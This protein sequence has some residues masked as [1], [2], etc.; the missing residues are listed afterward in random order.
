[1][2]YND[3]SGNLGEKPRGITRICSA[4]LLNKG[5]LA[6]WNCRCSN[7]A[8]CGG[9]TL[10]SVRVKWREKELWKDAPVQRCPREHLA[11]QAVF[12]FTGFSRKP[13]CSLWH[14]WALK[15][16]WA[17]FSVW[18]CRDLSSYRKVS[19]M[20]HLNQ[21]HAWKLCVA[22][23]VCL[24]MKRLESVMKRVSFKNTKKGIGCEIWVRFTDSPC[25]TLNLWQ[26]GPHARN[27]RSN[28]AAWWWWTQPWL[29]GSIHTLTHTH[30]LFT[31]EYHMAKPEKPWQTMAYRLPAS[32]GLVLLPLMGV[33][34]HPLTL[35]HLPS[36]PGSHMSFGR[37]NHCLSKKKKDLPLTAHS[38]S[39]Q[40]PWL[41]NSLVAQPWQSPTWPKR[42]SDP[43]QGLHNKCQTRQC[44]HGYG[45]VASI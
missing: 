10:E 40:P 18:S 39:L 30:K 13:T 43:C 2:K 14:A 12:G 6:A 26:P 1:M 28:S 3:V 5:A 38:N 35:S 24:K 32:M 37:L 19:V 25:V 42:L 16:P 11:L 23:P 8:L 4:N 27:S 7:P 36:F 9:E 44:H 22:T 33:N 20:F 34:H 21:S 45:G 31:E 29:G 41:C 17:C 15:L